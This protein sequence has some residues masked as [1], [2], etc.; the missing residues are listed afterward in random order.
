MTATSS[1]L[2]METFFNIIYQTLVQMF[3]HVSKTVH[4]CFSF[5][6]ASWIIY[7][8]ENLSGLSV[9]D[10]LKNDIFP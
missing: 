10:Q 1:N 4:A 5:V 2:K 7:E 6:L 9:V 8:F 3:D